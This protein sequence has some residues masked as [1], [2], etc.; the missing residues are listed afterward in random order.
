MQCLG[1]ATQHQA[2]RKHV[3]IVNGDPNFLEFVRELFQLYEYNV[4]T[5]N[6]VPRTFAQIE[7]LEPNLVIVDL[8]IG[9][10]MGWEL[11]ERLQFETITRDIPVIAVSTSCELLERARIEQERYGADR[12]VVKPLDIHDLMKTVQGLIGSS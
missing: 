8:V 4:T 3:F 11:L 1:V 7:A 6:F 9:Q 10:Q 12:Y 2:G 5:T